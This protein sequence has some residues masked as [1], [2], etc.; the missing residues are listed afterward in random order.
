MRRF[1]FLSTLFLTVLC[2]CHLSAPRQLEKSD[3]EN[4]LADERAKGF[5]LQMAGEC[6]KIT[7]NDPWQKSVNTHFTYYLR[8][9]G[10]KLP[11]NLG[12]TAI[13]T[14]PVRRVVCLSTTH[15]GFLDAL[16]EWQ[17]IIG[18]SG[19]KYLNNLHL[20]QQIQDGKL[21]EV[22]NENG[23]FYEKLVD[24]KPDV[25]FAFGVGADVNNQLSKLK[26]LGIPVVMVGEYLEATP[27]AKA[28]WLRFFGAFFD[29]TSLADSLFQEITNQYHTIK[30]SVKRDEKR[31]GV[32]TGLPF[33]ETWWM[34][35]GASNLARLIQDAGGEYLWGANDS[36][37]AFPVSLEE[38][39][40]RAAK[41]DFWI[42]C[43][44]A[45]SLDE[46]RQ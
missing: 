42:N 9:A 6:F 21:A 19:S 20:Q 35:G 12:D 30:S 32:L 37:E 14:I 43:G 23:L 45:N 2:S 28:E 3:S 36:R 24:L 39:F 22:G 7:V 1:I 11:E 41:A 44:T 16:D 15:A 25:V 27:L 10:A 26:D 40:I 13:F 29:K 4:G 17:S 5:S 18:I 38:V 34:A 8:R 31:P 46:L 33:K